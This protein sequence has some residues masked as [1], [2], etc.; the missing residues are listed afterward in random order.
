MGRIKGNESPEKPLT[1]RGP[2]SCRAKPGDSPG[3]GLEPLHA[4]AAKGLRGIRCGDHCR[5]RPRSPGATG[6]DR[7]PDEKGYG[8]R[9]DD[10]QPEPGPDEAGVPTTQPGK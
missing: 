10:A 4:T 5:R 6:R 3:W 8:R 9:G 2:C 7:D 1:S